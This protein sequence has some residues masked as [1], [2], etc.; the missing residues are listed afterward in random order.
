VTSTR[1][2][3][4]LRTATLPLI[5]VGVAAVPKAV[6]KGD[7]IVAVLHKLSVHQHVV[8]RALLIESPAKTCRDG[9]S[10]RSS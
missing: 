9:R 10:Q 3:L 6:G 7:K 1:G 2:P 5:V 4:R 8:L